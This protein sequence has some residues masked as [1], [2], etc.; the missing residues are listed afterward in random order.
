MLGLAGKNSESQTYYFL[1]LINIIITF[2]LCKLDLW[3]IY[4]KEYCR[5]VTATDVAH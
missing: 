2:L 1:T 3:G 5:T 4:K